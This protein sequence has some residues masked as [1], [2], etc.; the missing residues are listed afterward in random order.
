M[1]RMRSPVQARQVAYPEVSE[2]T[3][4]FLP[5]ISYMIYRAIEKEPSP[6]R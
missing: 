2:D 1:V 3:S 5:D 6:E 4:F